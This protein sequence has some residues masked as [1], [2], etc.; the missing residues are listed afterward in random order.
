MKNTELEMYK[1]FFDKV[2]NIIKDNKEVSDKEKLVI[3][4]IELENMIRYQHCGV[5]NEVHDFI[6]KLRN[7]ME[8]KISVKNYL[9]YLDAKYPKEFSSNRDISYMKA[10][11]ECKFFISLIRKIIESTSEI[12]DEDKLYVRRFFELLVN[13]YW[14]KLQ[15]EKYPPK[16][17]YS[18]EHAFDVIRTL[19][20]SLED[21]LKI[22]EL[23]EYSE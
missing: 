19:N 20:C 15:K 14:D 10:E 7:N 3:I 17:K 23:F 2:E 5:S 9:E 8:N 12:S 21:K 6:Q 18:A 16:P 4:F 11:E 1:G 22:A 13:E